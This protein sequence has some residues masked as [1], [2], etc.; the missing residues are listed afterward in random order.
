MLAH[1]TNAKYCI[2]DWRSWFIFQADRGGG[3]GGWVIVVSWFH[4]MRFHTVATQLHSWK[5][6]TG[7]PIRLTQRIC[8]G[9]YGKWGSG[10]SIITDFTSNLEPVQKHVNFNSTWPSRRKEQSFKNTFSIHKATY[11]NELQTTCSMNI[12]LISIWK[13]T[14]HFTTIHPHPPDSN[15][16][17]HKSP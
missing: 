5:D 16:W 13:L 12:K 17:L 3:E 6:V 11:R 8:L 2:A 7:Q 15:W 14:K 1:I 9:D 10:L 4:E